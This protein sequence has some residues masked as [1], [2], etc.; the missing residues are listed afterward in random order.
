M[1]KVSLDEMD[2]VPDSATV[3][4]PFTGSLNADEVSLNYYELSKEDSFAYGY[5]RHMKQEEIF[6][7]L[8]GVV[9]FETEEGEIKV[10]E[11][12]VIRFAPGEYQRGV[13]KGSERVK[14]YAVG[15]PQEMGETEILKECGY[16]GERTENTIAKEED[17]LVTRCLECDGV[18]ERF[19]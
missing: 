11:G 15:A 9:T 13:N 1:E 5:H 6:L 18:T 17:E 12:E 16:C 3:C 19:E 14:A 10:E 4:K 2:E 8:E 7:V